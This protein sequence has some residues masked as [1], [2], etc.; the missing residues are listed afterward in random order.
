MNI[1]PKTNYI[2]IKKLKA[3]ED[4]SG[5]ILPVGVEYNQL[6]KAEVIALGEDTLNINLHVG[7][8]VMLGYSPVWDKKYNYKVDNETFYVVPN[9][10]VLGRFKK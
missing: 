3:D 10:S 6:L 8:K 5:I 9:S 2:A 4:L 7:D 1:K